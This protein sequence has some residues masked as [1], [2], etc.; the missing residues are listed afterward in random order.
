MPDIIINFDD[1][2]IG[3]VEINIHRNESLIEERKK[4]ENPNSLFKNVMLVFTDG[5]SRNNFMRVFKKLGKWIEKFLP[6]K[7]NF[8]SYQLLKY[9]TT[10]TYIQSNVQPMFYGRGM[11]SKKDIQFTKC[12]RENGYISAFSFGQYALELFPDRELI[13]IS[14]TYFDGWEHYITGLFCNNNFFDSK[15]SLN[16]GITSEEIHLN[17]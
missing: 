1:K 17:M 2:N 7:I 14:D 4:L 5:V 13:F 12:Y 15:L 16:K 11:H 8:S 10:G 6:P 9:H 3:H